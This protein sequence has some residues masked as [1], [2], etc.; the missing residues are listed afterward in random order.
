M[1]H[2]TSPAGNVPLSQKVTYLVYSALLWGDGNLWHYHKY[3]DFLLSFYYHDFI[4][5]MKTN[6]VE[7]KY[8][9]YVYSHIHTYI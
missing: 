4:H 1:Y 6:F 9:F 2:G 7:G 8:L 5:K 3:V